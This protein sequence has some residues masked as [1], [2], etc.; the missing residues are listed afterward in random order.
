MVPR[1]PS[2]YNEDT[3][4]KGK[5]SLAFQQFR[6]KKDE[7]LVSL[8]MWKQQWPKFLRGEK[9]LEVKF[10]EVIQWLVT[11]HLDSVCVAAG[12]PSLSCVSSFG[13]LSDS[14]YPTCIR[15]AFLWVVICYSKCKIALSFSVPFSS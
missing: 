15:R 14:G 10:Q 3:I 11:I 4:K 2:E 1:P 8:A 13:L 6:K 7:V 5:S 9:A 12:P